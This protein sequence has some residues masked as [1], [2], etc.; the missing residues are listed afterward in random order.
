[1]AK[2]TI[3][4]EGERFLG[5]KPG[6]FK[7]REVSVGF[8]G[9]GADVIVTSTGTVELADIP[10]GAFVL[11]VLANIDTAWTATLTLTLGDGASAAGFHASADL[12]PQTAVSTGAYKNSLAS[13]EAYAGGK[14]YATADTIDVVIGVTAPLA[15]KMSVWIIYADQFSGLD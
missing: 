10:A 7:I 6:I 8:T 2:I 9:S 15:G 3:P 11:A 12:A 14:F 1:M 4:R 13:A 5:F